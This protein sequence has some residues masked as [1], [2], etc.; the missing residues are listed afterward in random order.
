MEVDGK[1]N[2]KVDMEFHMSC[3]GYWI[4]KTIYFC[5]SPYGD[6][7]DILKFRRF[8]GWC[9]YCKK[10]SSFNEGMMIIDSVE[11]EQGLERIE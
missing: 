5:A 9:P 10:V 6:K 7:P 1:P 4:K 11:I 2:W 3:C 8:V